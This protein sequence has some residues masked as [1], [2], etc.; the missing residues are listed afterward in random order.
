M[1]QKHLDEQRRG[2]EK[3]GRKGTVQITILWGESTK[4]IFFIFLG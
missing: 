1:N 2:G 3:E 4:E